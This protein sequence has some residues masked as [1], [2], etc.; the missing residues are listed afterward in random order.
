MP[1][2]KQQL[3]SSLG[4]YWCM[5]VIKH[6]IKYQCLSLLPLKIPKGAIALPLLKLIP[7]PYLIHLPNLNTFDN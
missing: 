6:I 5:F 3:G 4:D 2:H 1:S 7:K